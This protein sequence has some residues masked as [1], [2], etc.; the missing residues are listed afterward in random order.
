MKK[1]FTLIEVLIVL[2]IFSVVSLVAVDTFLTT[3]RISQRTNI[4]NT[5]IDDARYILA[6]L[7][8]EIQTN[9]IDFEEYFSQ[10]VIQGWC[11]TEDL[12]NKTSPG[13]F[14]MNYGYYNWQFFYG[15]AAKPDGETH[16]YGS[17]CQVDADTYDEFPNPDCA[18]GSLA[19]SEDS[20][21][22]VNPN[23]IKNEGLYDAA[24][25]FCVT[26]GQGLF[27]RFTFTPGVGIDVDSP[28]SPKNCGTSTGAFDYEDPSSYVVTELYLINESGTQKTI[29]GREQIEANDYV[30]SKVKLDKGPQATSDATDPETNLPLFAFTCAENY[31][32]TWIRDEIDELG[33]GHNADESFSVVDRTDFYNVSDDIFSDFVP[34]SPL[35]VNIKSLKFIVS[36]A[37]DPY[38]AFAE[39]D[40][41]I[42]SQPQVTILLELEPSESLRLP[43]ISDQFSLKFQTTVTSN[44]ISPV[45]IVSEE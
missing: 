6:N 17:R 28:N 31:V 22:G 1:G 44:V 11:P 32:C 12:S 13:S 36:P 33:L 15:G 38:R 26:D 43:F 24:N 41:I 16:G 34:I 35:R 8:R 25:A 5:I 42:L 10:C 39:D 14:G 3:F 37:E 45:P 2:S 27:Q 19:F 18:T 23:A 29:I 7:S 21:T 20:N 40:P 30:V 4:E 9:T